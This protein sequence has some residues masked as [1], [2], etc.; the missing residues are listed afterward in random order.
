MSVQMGSPR[1]TES[2]VQNASELH[3]GDYVIYPSQGVHRVAGFERLD[4]AGQQLDV[5]KLEREHDGATVI[6]P[7]EKVPATG[8]RRVAAR[9]LVEDVFHVLGAPGRQ[10]ERDWKERHREISERL[11]GGGVL[12]V[13]EVVKELYDLSRIRPP[14]PKE[15][16]QYDNARHLLVDEVAVS[17]AVPPGLAEDYIDYALTPP[18][19]VKLPLKPPPK[20][21]PVRFVPRRPEPRRPAE[22]LEEVLGLGE[23]ALEVSAPG[24]EGAPLAVKM[25]PKRHKRAAR[26]E[27]ATKTQLKKRAPRKRGAKKTPAA[28]RRVSKKRPAKRKSRAKR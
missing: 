1:G 24:E 25:K 27:R 17:M 10:V 16:K 7:V 20:P 5:L 21:E 3:A 11:M 13:T 22:E 26:S 8:L 19:G 4:I 9:E 23:V 12:G 6:V 15:R 14:P 28:K 2:V 18:A